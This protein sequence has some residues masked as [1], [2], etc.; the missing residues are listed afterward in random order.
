MLNHI[1]GIA[2]LVF[3]AMLIFSSSIF[4][5]DKWHLLPEKPGQW[6]YSYH[7]EPYG[8]NAEKNYKLTPI[9]LT[10]IRQKL[11]LLAETLHQNKEVTNPIGFDAVAVGSF[12]CFDEAAAPT[13]FPQSEVN[14]K[15]YPL[16][17]DNSGNI[18]RDWTEVSGIVFFLNNLRPGAGY[19]NFRET[20]YSKDV[21]LNNSVKKLNEIFT[22]PEILKEI[23]PG[24]TAFADGTVI[25]SKPDRPY[26]IPV[27]LGELYDLMLNYNK[28]QDIEY[29]APPGQGVWDALKKEK[30]SLSPEILDMPAYP[31]AMFPGSISQISNVENHF[32]YMRLNPDYFDKTLP[33]TAIQVITIRTLATAFQDESD[34]SSDS[35]DYTAH[36]K[37]ARVIDFNALQKL[38]EIK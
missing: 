15:F 33:K 20:G 30:E 1:S 13:R 31:G 36:C 37:F 35:P 10:T 8:P 29:K 27:K 22:R 4:A 19:F 2:R 28:L 24:I 25:I 9:E 11:S 5:Q 21:E 18:R 38:L 3:S 7:N 6:T 17:G 16:Y 26:W 14:L 32:P 34:C 12:Y 23:A